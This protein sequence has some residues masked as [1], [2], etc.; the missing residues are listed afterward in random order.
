MVEAKTFGRWR[1]TGHIPFIETHLEEEER[2]YVDGATLEDP[3]S[4]R[5]VFERLGEKPGIEPQDIFDFQKAVNYAL[6]QRGVDIAQ[7]TESDILVSKQMGVSREEML[8][9]RRDEMGL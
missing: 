5:Q 8:K 1:V 7:L 9:V 3:E 6:A 2:F 4:R